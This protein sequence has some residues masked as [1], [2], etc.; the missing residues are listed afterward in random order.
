MSA[1]LAL[2]MHVLRGVEVALAARVRMYSR[3][4]T[5]MPVQRRQQCI[6]HM[7]RYSLLLGDVAALNCAGLTVGGGQVHGAH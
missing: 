6:A 7:Y 5:H 1:V 3:L 4:S 2:C